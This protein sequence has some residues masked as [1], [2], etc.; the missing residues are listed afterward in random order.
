MIIVVL[1]S[2]TTANRVKKYIKQNYN[3]D[4][5][6]ICTHETESFGKLSMKFYNEEDVN[7]KLLDLFE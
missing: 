6:F 5:Y 2:V 3:K 1:P 4:V 7:K